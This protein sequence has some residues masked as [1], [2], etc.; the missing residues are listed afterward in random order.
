MKYFIAI[1]ACFALVALVVA[2]S[3]SE[4]REKAI[5]YHAE[6]AKEAGVT[7]TKSGLQ[8]KVIHDGTGKIHARPSDRV[9]VHY[10]GK[11]I[12]GKEF[13]SS[14]KRNAPATFG[15]NQVIKGWTE[16]LQLM[17][18]GGKYEFYIPWE[19][20]YGADG[21]QPNIPKY[22]PL[23]FVVELIDINGHTDL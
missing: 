6:K 20:A 14:Y 17:V 7:T 10:Q 19:L 9:K 3:D 13:D 21:R 12:D 23:E 2:D 11:L 1:I 16:G 15:L 5:K 22:A 8:Y 4:L 18:I